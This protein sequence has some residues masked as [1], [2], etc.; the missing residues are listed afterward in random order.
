MKTMFF[1]IKIF[2]FMSIGKS[3]I[4]ENVSLKQ[5]YSRRVK[6][7]ARRTT[8]ELV[9]SNDWQ[10]ASTFPARRCPSISCKVVGLFCVCFLLRLVTGMNREV[11][12]NRSQVI[13]KFVVEKYMQCG[14]GCFL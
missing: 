11:S 6:Q 12:I 9:P 4:A 5:V 13:S 3:S 2:L 7:G 1:L 14:S 8:A 10:Q